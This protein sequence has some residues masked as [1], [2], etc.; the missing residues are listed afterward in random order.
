M[1]CILI[2]YYFKIEYNLLSVGTLNFKCIT[3]NT[4]II[5]D[6]QYWMG[7]TVI[8]HFGILVCCF[9]LTFVVNV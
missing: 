5:P 7:I 8:I 1:H 6:F 3:S 4:I 9:I 2:K